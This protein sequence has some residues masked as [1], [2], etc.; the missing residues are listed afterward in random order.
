MKWLSDTGACC[1]GDEADYFALI[2]N[3]ADTSEVN[4]TGHPHLRP[5]PDDVYLKFLELLFGAGV[6]DVFRFGV[7]CSEFR[8]L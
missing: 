5:T 2:C 8:R 4:A 7:R 1:R 3:P 6:K